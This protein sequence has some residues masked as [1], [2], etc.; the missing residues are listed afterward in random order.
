MATKTKV[1]PKAKAKPAKAKAKAKPAKKPAA[2]PQLQDFLVA[3]DYTFGRNLAQYM[4]KCYGPAAFFLDASIPNQ[5]G[6]ASVVI[7]LLTNEICEMDAVDNKAPKRHRAYVW[8]NPKYEKAHAAESKARNI[9]AR[10]AWDDTKWKHVTPE[11][12]LARARQLVAQGRQFA[13]ERRV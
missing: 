13:R 12:V 3:V 7:D 1:K 9:D 4:W 8:R 2:A 11:Q 5:I 10:V 6:N